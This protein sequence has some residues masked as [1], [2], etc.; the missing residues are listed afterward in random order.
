[1]LRPILLTIAW[2]I[3]LAYA[4]IPAF[5][6]LVHPFAARW[7]G[8]RK[9]YRFLVPLWLLCFLIAG[10]A[11]LPF[12]RT[13]LYDNWPARIGGGLLV[14]AALATYRAVGRR[15]HFTGGQL[16]GRSE[17]E[18]GQQQ[19]LVTE[20]MHARVRHPIYLAALLMISGWT[21]GSG[22]L[23]DLLLLAWA[24]AAFPVM[25]ALEERELVA[26]FGEAY[27]EYKRRVPAIIPGPHSAA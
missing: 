7:R 1:M 25:I 6:F 13:Q 12:A 5:W 19:R 26:R 4:M 20:G 14:A 2:V 11:T 9:P 15:K 21:V 17:V 22:L 8:V 3:P 18:A 27:R 16:V 10:A 23:A 24:A